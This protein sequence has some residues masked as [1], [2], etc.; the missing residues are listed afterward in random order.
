M[1][2][3]QR[4]S[5]LPDWLAGVLAPVP[6]DA[7]VL[8]RAGLHL[9]RLSVVLV[10][11]IS[12]LVGQGMR[13]T[14]EEIRHTG[15]L[16]LSGEYFPFLFVLLSLG[17]LLLVSFLMGA[18]LY[19]MGSFFFVMGTVVV[20]VGVLTAPL[21]NLTYAQVA[22]RAADR[23]WPPFLVLGIVGVPGL[24]LGAGTLPEGAVVM[25]PGLAFLCLAVPPSSRRWLGSLEADGAPA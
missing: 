20:V 9:W 21:L 22:R 6:D 16:M 8:A 25:V 14:G 2:E 12:L 1:A 17:F 15:S 11:L 18:M 13:T 7:P 3:E 4:S 23:L 19:L 10:P 24:A 5:G